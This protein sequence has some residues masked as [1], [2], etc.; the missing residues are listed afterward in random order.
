MIHLGRFADVGQQM[1]S[2][3]DMNEKLSLFVHG[4]PLRGREVNFYL[5]AG[6]GEE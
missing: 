1:S 4:M 5:A 6:P 3:N 2:K